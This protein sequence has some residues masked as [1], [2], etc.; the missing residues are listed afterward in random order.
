MVS[1]GDDTPPPHPS[2]RRQPW[3]L[4]LAVGLVAVVVALI[5]GVGDQAVSPPPGPALPEPAPAT[6][7][8]EAGSVPL[9][10]GW[11]S[12]T[13]AGTGRVTALTPFGEGFAAASSGAFGQPMLWV[14]DGELVWRPLL[15]AALEGGNPHDLLEVE[16]RLLVVGGETSP[17]H[18]PSFPLPRVWWIDPVTQQSES[19]EVPVEAGALLGVAA[20]GGE[21]ITWGVRWED[22]TIWQS[23]PPR[24]LLLQLTD[25]GL[26]EVQLEGARRDTLVRD[27]VPLPEGGWLAVGTDRGRAALWRSY[28]AGGPF[29]QVRAEF[30]GAPRALTSVA[31]LPDGTAV[32]AGDSLDG[33][34]WRSRDLVEWRR[35]E[36]SGR[37]PE[38]RVVAVPE[39]VLAIYA[40][41]PPV[42]L[43]SR[44]GERW[45]P[46]DEAFGGGRQRGWSELTAAT[47]GRGR[48]VV[49]GA[50]GGEP[51]VWV[52][53]ERSRVL[54]P[55]QPHHW[56]VEHRLEGGGPYPFVG[57]E[58]TGDG[59]LAAA[60]RMVEWS[61]ATG[62]G[63]P[64]T[65]PASFGL[66]RVEA[67][68][69]GLFLLGYG[70][71]GAQIW[72][73]GADGEIE[74]PE[75]LG[76]QG[77]PWAMVTDQAG[78][79]T[80]AAT[81]QGG[82]RVAHRSGDG[83]WSS[84]AVPD[85]RPITI[86]S[87]G[88]TLLVMDADATILQ[89]HDG[90]AWTPTG[91]RGSLFPGLI[92]PVV[93]TEL[94]LVQWEASGPQPPVPPPTTASVRRAW[95]VE[96]GWVV[97]SG[98]RLWW[99]DGDSDW[100]PVPL[101]PMGRVQGHLVT[102]LVVDGVLYALGTENGDLV[103]WRWAAD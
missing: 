14:A 39:G 7:L 75:A 81:A 78:E 100:V 34:L 31:L 99:R 54:L 103:V 64:R 94:D 69:S 5:G 72:Q 92:S 43:F 32:A 86:T 37:G 95:K 26:A 20:A 102:P 48:V 9:A 80:V 42:A 40:S 22:A 61:P 45:S 88:D 60:D 4:A 28:D 8:P 1:L 53:G 25:D 96:G 18:L 77:Q 11:R 17:F 70:P 87:V 41:G 13:L 59:V 65:I 15:D 68:R 24:P 30:E 76:F 3:G 82:M 55:D 57:V 90:R 67:T 44:D 46:I 35:L 23:T 56:V 93:L 36:L 16:G 71:A 84:W 49:G 85:L 38:A 27:M 73:V 83:T 10:A 97:D 58:L 50:Q 29:R 51:A 91:V 19:W 21:V 12:H 79:L 52:H 66:A 6:T 2:R 101:G 62:F 63:T 74:E 47:A 89:S 98:S 33:A